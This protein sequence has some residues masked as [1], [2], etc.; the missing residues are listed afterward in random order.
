MHERIPIYQLTLGFDINMT[1]KEYKKGRLEHER[2]A[3]IW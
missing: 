3:H 2:K 1:Q